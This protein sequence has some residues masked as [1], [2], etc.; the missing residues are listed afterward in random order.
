MGEVGVSGVGEVGRGG[1]GASVW[2]CT[3]PCNPS[4]LSVSTVT[5]LFPLHWY[6]AAAAL[7]EHNR[8]NRTTPATPIA[9]RPVQRWRKT[10]GVRAIAIGMHHVCE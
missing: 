4:G 3:Q 9:G 1:D 6:T 10:D 7:L 8:L 5:P 2:I